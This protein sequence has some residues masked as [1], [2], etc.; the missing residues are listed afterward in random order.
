MTTTPKQ[1]VLVRANHKDHRALADLFGKYRQN[2]QGF[3]R[4]E[5]TDNRTAKFVL[6]RNAGFVV[7]NA[8]L[9]RFTLPGCG[10]AVFTLSQAVAVGRKLH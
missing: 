7:A 3:A 9:K 2:A 6:L 1:L 4:Y 5:M 8:K 10:K